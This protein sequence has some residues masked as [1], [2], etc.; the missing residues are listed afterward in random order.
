MANL[1]VT[2]FFRKKRPLGNFSI[3]NSFAEVIRAWPH[4]AN[5]PQWIE[6]TDYSEGVSKRLNIIRSARR[7]Q[8]DI[9]HITG[10]IHFA[11]L[12]WPK[13]SKGRPKLVLTIHDLGF[14]VESSRLKLWF[15]RKF[16]IHWPL[17]CVDHLLVV[18][19][20]TKRSVLEEVPWFDRSKVSVVPTVIPAHFK[21]RT[22]IP[23][24]TKTVALHI[25]L[26]K[27]KNLIGHAKALNGLE[28]HLRIIGEP[29][30]HDHEILHE[31]CIEY[32]WTSRLNDEEMQTEYANA[33]FLLFASTLEGFGMPILEAQVVGVPV[34]TSN[35]SP[36]KEVAGDGAILVDPNDTQSIRSGVKRLIEDRAL[37]EELVSTTNPSRFMA[38]TSARHLSD[39]YS[40]L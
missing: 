3:E 18:S 24:N 6:A 25:G 20:A 17:R 19:T 22:R 9:L 23:Q 11:A 37:A 5:K 38:S 14:L 16:W 28:I 32:S 40:Q 12:A 39:L 13:W 10:D 1:S 2:W 26:A 21:R 15:I 34:I 33:D 29:S 8:T 31:Q 7:V 27:N 36:M 4:N 35:I 30:E